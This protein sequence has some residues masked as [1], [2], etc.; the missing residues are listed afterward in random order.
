MSPIKKIAVIGCGSV[1]LTTAVGLADST[2][3][4]V[5]IDKD[6]NKLD[7]IN[8][9]I[10]P[11]YE[12]EL[13]AQ[14]NNILNGSSMFETSEDF[15]K[16]DGSD[17]VFVC[18]GTPPSKDGNINLSSIKECS[19]MIGLQ[20]MSSSNCPVV[21]IR[22]TVVP[23]TTE[24]VVLPILEKYSGK[25]AGEGFTLAA[26]P[27]FLQ[28]GKAYQNFKNPDR[29]IIGEYDSRAGEILESLYE[30]INTPIIRTN[31][32]T[33]EMIKCA[34]N[35]F[36]GTKISFI[37][38]IGNI[39]KKLDIDVYDVASG[40]GQDPRIGRDFLNAGLGFG[41]SCLP[42]DINSLIYQ[43]GS[44]GLD[45][46]VLKSIYETNQ[47]QIDLMLES[48]RE[49]LGNLER[50]NITILGLTFKPDT[51]DTREA[52]AFRIIAELLLEKANIKVYDPMVSRNAEF[53]H[54]DE[55]TICES[56][57]EAVTDSEGIIIVTGWDEFKDVN[58]YTGKTV[59]DGRRVLDPK[60][61]RQVCLHY[62]GV[63]W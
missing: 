9:G 23:G 5:C 4:I 30:G 16:I 6:S 26:N 17:V 1:G 45:P 14:L 40:I 46:R 57:T 13:E 34:S 60:Q 61:A 52:S 29:V 2:R 59:F 50:K 48:V 12:P 39:C 63:S 49:R 35:A 41:G 21:V 22:S 11:F 43:A 8:N 7:M 55:V 62:E 33:A 44:L 42:K 3:R 36:L 25:K 18:V 19:K 28:E 15:S 31:I 54:S 27:E 24:C 58:I 56:I 51:D 38:E 47:R 10:C 37:N 32:R 53:P 20:I